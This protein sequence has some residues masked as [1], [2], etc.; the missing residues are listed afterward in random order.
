MVCG[1]FAQKRK[2]GQKRPQIKAQ[3]YPV[4]MLPERLTEVKEKTRRLPNLNKNAPF[5]NSHLRNRG[6][7]MVLPQ[8]LAFLA[9][10]TTCRQPD[11]RGKEICTDVLMR[12]RT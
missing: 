4:R 10:L 7:Q 1:E 5:L 6:L 9:A 11:F 12:W 2:S 8:I 3:V